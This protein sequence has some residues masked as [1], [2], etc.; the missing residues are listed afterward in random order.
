MMII[1]TCCVIDEMTYIGKTLLD[2]YSTEHYA[3]LLFSLL[4]NEEYNG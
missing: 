2:V 4:G 3:F 1:L